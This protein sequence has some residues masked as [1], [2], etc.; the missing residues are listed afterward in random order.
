MKSVLSGWRRFALG[1]WPS[2]LR[3]ASGALLLFTLAV[4]Y[5]SHETH[6]SL[7]PLPLRLISPGEEAGAGDSGWVQRVT[8]RTGSPLDH[9]WDDD[10]NTTDL[11]RY[12][13][14]PPLLREAFVFAEDQ[15][16]FQHSGVDWR[17]RAHAVVQNLAAL[18][19]VRGASTISEQSVRILHPRRRTVWSRWLEGFEAIR[20]ERRFDK[21]E[22][23]EFYLN[24]VPYSRQRRGVVQAARLYFDRDL[25]TLA[26]SEML[27]LA[28]LVR[29]P[30]RLDPL[31]D[32]EALLP[33]VERL[34]GRLHDAG[35]IDG[36]QLERI[37]KANLVISLPTPPVEANHWT[38]FVRRACQQTE[39]ASV[40][41][42]ALR[43]SL[44]GSLQDRVQHILDGELDRLASRQVGDGAV[45]V[46]DHRNDQIL[47][48]VNG[49]GFDKPDG[50][51]IDKVLAPR[52]PGSTLK[53][54][55]YALALEDGW[56]AAT[57]IEDAPL[58]DPVGNGMHS[59]RNYSRTF[60]GPVRL[61]EAL[62]NSLNTP[63]IRAVKFVGTDRFLHRLRRLGL[64]SLRAH[65]DFY[66][67]GLALGNGEVSLHA[68]VGAYAALAR[69]GVWRALDYR[70]DASG[71]A[72]S[73]AE[74][75]FSREAATLISDILSDPQARRLEFGSGSILALPRQTAVKTGTSNDHRDAWAIGYSERFT[76]GVWMGNVDRREML[77]VSGSV[78]PALVFRSVMAEL[79]RN[80]EERPLPLS[81]RL[82]SHP[83]CAHS[84]ATPGDG[85]PVIR[86]WFL[87]GTEPGALRNGSCPLHGQDPDS[88]VRP[89]PPRRV[90]LESPTP[91]LHLALDPRIPDSLERFAFE[92][93]VAEA[94]ERVE[95]LVDGSLVATTGAGQARYAWPLARGRHRVLARVWQRGSAGPEDTEEIGFV[96]K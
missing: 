17:A 3:F 44:D 26:P 91:G 87:P 8:D 66:G 77:N 83:V 65:P 33:G 52:Q 92:L 55:L 2:S 45:L 69:G 75:V 14:V 79:N 86:E 25:D 31:K 9:R 63:A 36:Q 18:R 80:R 57:L 21:A 78:G 93:S 81:R 22:I 50:G 89:P 42:R 12:H 10:Y 43:S 88:G 24:Q 23:L 54:F 1:R 61:R 74:R 48:W 46:V 94:I 39:G 27:A 28:V 68:L 20:L 96:V 58:V 16:F 53:P 6:R 76:V 72:P 70:V 30:S 5:L 56:T 40:K 37:L 47:A 85:C 64:D 41:G 51:Q 4:G 49:G 15:R 29:S 82:T 95:W 34:A 73:A 84:G 59:Y 35:R 32:S 11:I 13:E 67:E 38:D 62:G 19:A 90:A 7:R 71:A 60:Y